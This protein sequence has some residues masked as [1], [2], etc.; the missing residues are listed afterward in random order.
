MK[1]VIIVGG[2]IAGL[3]CA[4]F[5]RGRAR[6]TLLEESPRWGGVIVTEKT[7]GFVHEGGPDS[8]LPGK[9]EPLELCRELGV[10]LVA[11]RPGRVH[12]LRREGLHPLPE[13]LSLGLPTR[14]RPFL[15]TSLLSWEGKLRAGLDLVHHRGTLREDESVGAFLR[16]RLGREVVRLLVEPLLGGIH[17]TRTEDLSLQ[18]TF[19]HWRELERR[20]RSLILGLRRGPRAGPSGPMAPARGMSEL[21]ERLVERLHGEADLR[22]GVKAVRVSRALGPAGAVWSVQVSGGGTWEADELVLAVPAPRAAALLEAT[23]RELADL[24]KGIPYASSTVVSLGFRRPPPTEGTGFV[25]CPET[26]RGLV[27]CTWSS[28]KFEGRA[29]GGAWLA[30]CFFRDLPDDP[31]SAALEELRSAL[32][33]RDRPTAVRVFRW[34]SRRPRYIVGHPSRVR[35]IEERT[36]PSLHLIGSAYRG[37]GVADC[38]RDARRAADRIAGPVGRLL[39]EAGGKEGRP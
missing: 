30:R 13:G 6:V 36:P 29:P 3:S 31:V 38:L 4:W 24:V 20:H 27:A 1:R 35:R 7:D 17:L 2:G 32:G 26:G 15:S 21:I 19:P 33:M 11:A 25:V 9:P 5:L 18:A 34:A 37:A 28:Q 22:P 14:L 39:P 23:E 12:L 8:F 16:R 10:E